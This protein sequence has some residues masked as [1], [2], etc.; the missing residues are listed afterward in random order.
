M[1]SNWDVAPYALCHRYGSVLNSF[2][3]LLPGCRHL[4]W[5]LAGVALAGFSTQP[6]SVLQFGNEGVKLIGVV[7]LF[8]FRCLLAQ[9]VPILVFKLCEPTFLIAFRRIKVEFGLLQVMLM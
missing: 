8:G 5:I 3:M 2:K 6:G 7:A 1:L 4:L 9:L